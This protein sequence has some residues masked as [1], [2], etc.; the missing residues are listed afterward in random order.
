MDVRV[1]MG[2]ILGIVEFWQSVLVWDTKRGLEL[3]A[4]RVHF[5]LGLGRISLIVS[6]HNEYKGIGISGDNSRGI[7]DKTE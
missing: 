7:F 2:R 3:G 1:R 4:V 6:W 5:G